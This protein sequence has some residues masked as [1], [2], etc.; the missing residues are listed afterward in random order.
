[1]L[2]NGTF[3]IRDDSG[4]VYWSKPTWSPGAFMWLQ[5]TGNLVIQTQDESVILWQ[6]NTMGT[7]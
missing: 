6:T 3:V 7:C 1:M 2:S 5:D 4:S